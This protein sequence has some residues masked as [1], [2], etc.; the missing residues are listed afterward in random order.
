MIKILI[1]LVFIVLFFI[2]KNRCISKN[3]RIVCTLTTIPERVNKGKLEKTLESLHDQI[4]QPDIII[5]NIPKTT[6]TGQTYDMEK[7][8]KLAQ[9]YNNVKVNIVEKDL[10]PITKIIPTLEFIQ[11]DDKVV[12]VDD[13]I[14]Y[15]KN[16]IKTLYEANLPEVGF[17]GRN[18]L[19]WTDNK[20][21]TPLPTDFL[22][23]YGGV[24]YNGYI[25]KDLKPDE[26][27][28]C[29]F[30]DDIVIGN[31]LKNKNISP[32]L[33]NSSHLK[34]KYN[35]YGTP[36]LRDRNLVD[37]NEICYNYLFS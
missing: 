10:G 31:H 7:I 15:D 11:D 35:S 32:F 6:T 8:H 30:Q 19:I 3:H 37:G 4:L 20:K 22:E 13:D 14:I 29:K 24:M 12:I 33:I 1:L 26:S 34:I 9:K 28:I 36:Q 2:V 16:M 21:N 18:N 17:Y 23:T 25:I 5:L 27:G